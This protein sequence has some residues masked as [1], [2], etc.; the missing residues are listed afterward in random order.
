VSGTSKGKLLLADVQ[1]ELE[2]SSPGIESV[3]R[4]RTTGE[5]SIAASESAIFRCGGHAITRVED[6]S[7]R[8]AARR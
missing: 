5:G 4:V 8:G 2:K 1:R 3:L 7:R 6:S